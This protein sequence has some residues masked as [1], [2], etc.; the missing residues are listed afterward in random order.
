M[1]DTY[2]PLDELA[3]FNR[4]IEESSAVTQKMLEE[5]FENQP[6]YVRHTLDPLNI[7]PAFLHLTQRMLENPGNLAAG[8]MAF[9]QDYMKLVDTSIQKI[10]GFN[11]DATEASFTADRR[12]NS[13]NWNDGPFDFIRQ[14]YLLASQHA[15]NSVS[16][17]SGLSDDD[18]KKV[19]FYTKQYLDALSPSNFV[20]TNPD[21]LRAT[22]ESGGENI[23]SGL[24]HLL[25]DLEANNGM[26]LVKMTD[27]DAFK[28]G[29]NLATTPGKVVFRNHLFELIQYT[30]TT[31]EV[32]STPLVIFPPWINKFYILDLS[33]QKSFVKWVVD[34]GYTVFVV[35]WVN[36]TS[37][38]RDMGF[39]EYVTKGYLEALQ[40]VQEI[41]GEKNAHVIGYCVAGTMLMAV[42]AYLHATGREK[43]VRSATLFTAQ[44]DFADAGELSIFVDDDQLEAI[45]RQMDEKGFL[46]KRAMALTFNML[47]SND[48]IWSYVV[49]NYLLGKEPPAFDLL[50]WNCDSTNLAK[51][52]HSDYLHEMYRNN[53]LVKA[54]AIKIKDVPIDLS[55]IVTPLYV[56]AGIQDHIAP[57]VSVYKIKQHA[58]GPIR[59]VL[60]GSGHIAGVINPPDAHKYQYW[61]Y[62]DGALP[63]TLDAFKAAATETAGSWWPDWHS[64]LSK[65][66]GK[67]IAARQPDKGP[68]PVLCDAPGTYVMSSGDT[69]LPAAVQA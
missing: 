61:T 23:I 9:F 30:P 59:F 35:S 69:S 44:V 37:E 22:F 66:S 38:Y 11:K 50:F 65:R 2:V 19:S 1:S 56:Q 33:A 14:F 31:N 32:Y 51:R 13:E 62:D 41:T 6:D 63:D 3:D 20:L 57:A 16:E 12:F 39:D 34:Q 36:P 25:E 52:M 29:A 48:L 42:L 10:Q 8:Q 26:P 17:V 28:V 40:V 4:I 18:K 53:N 7:S 49:N 5:F 64:W 60:A 21:V 45:D 67:K 27:L 46:D 43:W 54:G 55:K 47:R 58:K 15:M 68:Y 24:Q